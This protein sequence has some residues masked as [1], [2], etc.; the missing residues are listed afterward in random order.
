MHGLRSS[1]LLPRKSIEQGERDSPECYETCI[2]NLPTPP[3]SAKMHGL[4]PSD[5]FMRESIE[6]SKGDSSDFHMKERSTLPKNK[7]EKSATC[8]QFRLQ[9]LR[10]RP[11]RISI[12]NINIV[13]LFKVCGLRSSELLAV[14]SIEPKKGGG[15]NYLTRE[16]STVPKNKQKEPVKYAKMHA[17]TSSE[18]LIRE[19]IEPP[20][21]DSPDYQ[22]KVISTVQKNKSEEPTTVAKMHGLRSSELLARESIEPATGD[23]PESHMRHLTTFSE[24]KMEPSAPQI[25][26]LPAPH[27]LSSERDTTAMDHPKHT[28]DEI[29]TFP[30]IEQEET[31]KFTKIHGSRH[32][33]LANVYLHE[34]VTGD[35]LEPVYK[36]KSTFPKLKVEKPS[37]HTKDNQ[38]Q[39]EARKRPSATTGVGPTGECAEGTLESK[40]FRSTYANPEIEGTD[41]DEAPGEGDV[42]EIAQRTT[43]E[44]GGS[45]RK[46]KDTK[47]DKDAERGREDARIEKVSG[48]G[49][50]EAERVGET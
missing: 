25:Y 30:K 23:T 4:K 42:E 28:M 6:P 1:E 41:E 10:Q 31:S 12:G 5:L 24:N 2:S 40:T 29:S 3:T 35:S 15:P 46:W 50:G 21:G 34:P 38:R 20:K 8:D 11:N 18:H 48:G 17:M 47:S 39:P 19:T 44:D 27:L 37:K 22:V 33:D 32:R 26:G 49:S 43:E 36:D 13:L 45:E 9:P 14:D 7:T 16:I